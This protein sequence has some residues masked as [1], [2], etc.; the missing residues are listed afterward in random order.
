VT[1]PDDLATADPRWRELLFH[2]LL[3][4]G[5]Y[6]SP[7]GYL[8]LTMDVT[9]DDTGRLLETVAEFCD[10]RGSLLA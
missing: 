5:F 10:R 2:D 1:S 9:D 3:A 8:A 7:R 6:I 4:A